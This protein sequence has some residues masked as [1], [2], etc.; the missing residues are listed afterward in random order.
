MIER[1]TLEQELADLQASRPE[2]PRPV[3]ALESTEYQQWRRAYQAWVDRKSVVE[4]L[5]A[6]VGMAE[7]DIIIPGP[8][9]YVKK[10]PHRKRR[11][12]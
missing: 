3:P 1:V 8:M 7:R 9:G 5:L 2:L 10:A 6:G 12:A 11:A 4:G